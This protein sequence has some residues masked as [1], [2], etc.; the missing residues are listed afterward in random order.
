[1]IRPLRIRHRW[2]IVTIAL[3]VG[4]LMV[5]GLLARRPIPTME[6]LPAVGAAHGASLDR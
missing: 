6:N 5:L 2:M 3:V 1:M 4:I